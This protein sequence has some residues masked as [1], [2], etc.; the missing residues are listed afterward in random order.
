MVIDESEGEEGEGEEG[1]LGK[2]RK[3]GSGDNKFLQE[4][5]FIKHVRQAYGI[6]GIRNIL[7]FAK[8]VCRMIT[9]T[10]DLWLHSTTDKEILERIPC[11]IRVCKDVTSTDRTELLEA[12]DQV[13]KLSSELQANFVH[14][15]SVIQ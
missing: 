10:V 3:P 4:A 9:L 7:E 8:M 15:V 1:F 5:P 12:F 14:L 13:I 2:K 11:E 6:F